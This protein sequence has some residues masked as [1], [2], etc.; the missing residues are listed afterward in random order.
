MPGT[1]RGSRTQTEEQRAWRG[2]HLGGGFE[3]YTTGPPS[4]ISIASARLLDCQCVLAET[5]SL[6]SV[7]ESSRPAL[8]VGVEFSCALGFW[9]CL[10]GAAI[11]SG[12][13]TKITPP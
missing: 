5:F 11:L 10:R 9:C 1:A 7:E 13:G 2:C 3:S 6:V 4:S 12:F 8:Q